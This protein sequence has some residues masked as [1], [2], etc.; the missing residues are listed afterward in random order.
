MLTKAEAMW[1]AKIQR[2]LDN[3]PSKRLG[4]YT[5]GDCDLTIY[6]GSKEDEIVAEHDAGGGEFGS[7]VDRCD[8]RLWA[9]HFPA[10][11][12]STSG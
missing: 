6:D 10:S 1:I 11:V 2:L 7:A 5:T 12:H 4:F 3:P 8:A 9:L